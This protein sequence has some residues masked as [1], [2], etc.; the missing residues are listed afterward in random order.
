MIRS[1]DREPPVVNVVAEPIQTGE[2]RE[3]GSSDHWADTRYDVRSNGR[4]ADAPQ[5]QGRPTVIP[6]FPLAESVSMPAGIS[7]GATLNNTPGPSQQP[8]H[9]HFLDDENRAREDAQ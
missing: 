7:P 2:S 1:L 6:C 3:L 8:V 5:Q 4:T 9:Q